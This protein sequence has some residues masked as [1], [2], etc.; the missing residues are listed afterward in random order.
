[1]TEEL[2]LDQMGEVRAFLERFSESLPTEERPP[3]NLAERIEQSLSA[4]TSRLF[5]VVSDGR[6]LALGSCGTR[7][8]NINF[9]LS[10]NNSY[11]VSLLRRIHSDFAEAGATYVVSA[12]RW[13]NDTL[14]KE[15]TQLGFEKHDRA[16][17]SMPAEEILAIDEPVLVDGYRFAPYE[18][19][20]R[21]EISELMALSNLNN[22]DL[23]VFPHFFSSVEACNLLV[24]RI[25]KSIY[26]TYHPGLSWTVHHEGSAVGVCFMTTTSEDTG[27]VPEIAVSPAHRRRGLGRAVLVHSMKRLIESI[28]TVKRTRLDVTLDNVARNLYSSVGFKTEL[29]YPM[30]TWTP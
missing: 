25:E 19:G 26:G 30:Y 22:V 3:P 5:A 4:G 7:T 6:V 20:M 27:Y 13:I 21:G 14:S 28:D 2:R 1:M 16:Q 23:K 17:M 24:E 29:E 12:G 18:E 15:L 11:S 10:D 8:N 9:V